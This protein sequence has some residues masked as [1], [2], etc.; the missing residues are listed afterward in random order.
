MNG[1]A[2]LHIPQQQSTQHFLTAENNKPLVHASTLN[3]K[4]V[5]WQ[6][7]MGAAYCWF[8]SACPS[9][10]ILKCAVPIRHWLVKIIT[11]TNVGATL[12]SQLG[13][14]GG[15]GQCHPNPPS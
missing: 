10:A 9:R 1:S 6:P 7:A 8:H 11:F 15:G 13:T 4:Q 14:N 5:G 12:Q 2:R 3:P